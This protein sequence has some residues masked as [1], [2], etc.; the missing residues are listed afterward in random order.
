[1]SKN[2]WAIFLGI[3]VVALASCF[4]CGGV[5]VLLFV[6]P[7]VQKAADRSH[8]QGE[9]RKL[10]NAMYDYQNSK[11]KPPSRV[12]DLEAAGFLKDG[13]VAGKVRSGRYEVVWNASLTDDEQ[14]KGRAN[15]LL[16]WDTQQEKDGSWLVMMGDTF[17][18]TMSNDEFQR[19]P[20]LRKVPGK[21]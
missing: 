12:D 14:P 3:G 5:A 1:V 2:N 16:A 19:A 15:C 11:L 18:K 20:K 6:V 13:E 21:K 9:L 10:G 7:A 4:C 17:C 8:R